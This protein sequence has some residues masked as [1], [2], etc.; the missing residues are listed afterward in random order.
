[1]RLRGFSLMTNILQDYSSDPAIQILVSAKYIYSQESLSP[2]ASGDHRNLDH[3]QRLVL[4]FKTLKVMECVSTWPL[5][6]RNKIEDSKINIAVQAIADTAAPDDEANT[7]IESERT[8]KPEE[9][10]TEPLEPTNLEST[11]KDADELQQPIKSEDAESADAPVLAEPTNGVIPM[12]VDESNVESERGRTSERYE[13]QT[14]KLKRLATK[15]F[16]LQS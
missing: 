3:S 14:M 2:S 11:E 8:P 12:A 16:A 5:L 13:S 6:Q 9:V 4:T 7:H 15:V 1:M 10:K